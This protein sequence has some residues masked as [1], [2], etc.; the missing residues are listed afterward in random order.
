MRKYVD[1]NTAPESIFVDGHLGAI[2]AYK[3][4]RVAEGTNINYVRFHGYFYS[5]QIRSVVS[6]RMGGKAKVLKADKY[7]KLSFLE[8]TGNRGTR[9]RKIDRAELMAQAFEEF[10]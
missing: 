10:H 5:P 4:I 7:N 9:A 6:V 8:D 3:I 1:F 2:E